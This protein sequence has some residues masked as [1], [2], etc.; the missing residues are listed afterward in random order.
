[1]EEIWKASQRLMNEINVLGFQ[2]YIVGGA[3]R[4]YLLKRPIADVDLVTTA[5]P[6][7]LLTHFPKSFQ[8]NNQHDTVLIKANNVWF[9]V[10]TQNGVSLEEDL[11]S[12]DFTINSMAL[13]NERELIDPYHGQKDLELRQIRSTEPMKSMASDPL[14][15]LRAIRFTAELGFELDVHVEEAIAVYVADLQNVAMERIVKEIEKIWR[16]SH[17]K[18]ATQTEA[19]ATILKNL[20]LCA[21]NDEEMSRLHMWDNPIIENELFIWSSIFLLKGWSKLTA[22]KLPLSKNLIKGVHK[23]LLAYQERYEQRWNVDSL[24]QFGIEVALDVED[25]R[26]S[27][28]FS[29]IS[30]QQLHEMVNAMAIR[31]RKDL[32]IDGRSLMA[33]YPEKN[34]GVWI[35]TC[36][37]IAETLV[38]HEEVENDAELIL[39][40]LKRRECG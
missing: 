18:E 24:Y 33:A 23:R 13:S 3:V 16:G 40:A 28:G 5:A 31:S 12:R 1:M 39:A 11:K 10:T 17:F 22:P 21:F 15:M 4:D 7:E 8:L 19:A 38:L 35:E 37:R 27:F 2:A 25:L 26:K 9:E 6:S 34:P 32:R 29:T 14:R 30:A 36:L 20:P